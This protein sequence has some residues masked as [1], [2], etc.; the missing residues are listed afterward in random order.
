MLPLGTISK[1]DSNMGIDAEWTKVV[2]HIY[3]ETSYRQEYI[4]LPRIFWAKKSWTLKELHLNFFDYIKDIL[5]RWLKDI[6][7]YETSDRCNQLPNYKHNGELVTFDMFEK[8]TL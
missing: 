4:N 6:K 2:F 7:E 3:Q 1:T 8:L 5:R